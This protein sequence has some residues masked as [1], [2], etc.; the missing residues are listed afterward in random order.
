[1]IID[2]D[3]AWTAAANLAS[4]PAFAGT[5]HG[6]ADS[7]TL[8]GLLE[9]EVVVVRNPFYGTRAEDCRQ[10][11]IELQRLAAQGH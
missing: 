10:C 7:G 1:M 2:E 9:S 4:D 5:Q 3:G 6:M 11:A 8:C